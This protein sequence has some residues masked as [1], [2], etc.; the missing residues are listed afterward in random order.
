M[1][2]T[3]WDTALAPHPAGCCK[4]RAA[5]RPDPCDGRGV[6]HLL[7][8]PAGSG[9]IGIGPAAEG[10]GGLGAIAKRYETEAESF[11]ETYKSRHLA[12]DHMLN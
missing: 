4:D 2:E 1:E 3:A 12:P 11:L 6:G 5:A 8:G 7:R 10:P 9:A